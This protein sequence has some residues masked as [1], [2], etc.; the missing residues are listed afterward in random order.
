MRRI[1]IL[2]GWLVW[3]PIIAFAQEITEFPAEPTTQPSSEAT[4]TEVAD[5][6]I[7][8]A[9]NPTSP[10]TERQ[11]PK[12]KIRVDSNG[13]LVIEGR[14]KDIADLDYIYEKLLEDFLKTANDMPDIRFYKCKNIDVQ[15]LS[16]MLDEIFNGSSRAR[17]QA[18]MQMLQQQRAA[19]RAARSRRNQPG[20]EGGPQDGNERNAPEE[21][22]AE[23]TGIPGLDALFGGSDSSTAKNPLESMGIRVVPETQRGILWIVAATE[24][25]PSII[26]VIHT[27]DTEADVKRDYEVVNLSKLDA[28]EVKETIVE[29][30]GLEDATA[31]GGTRAVRSMN[32]GAQGED[33]QALAEQ[34]QQ[35]MIQLGEGASSFS[36]KDIRISSLPATNSII[37]F[38]PEE[39]RTSVVEIIK[40]VDEQGAETR[41]QSFALENANAETLAKT[42]EAVYSVSGGAGNR[43]KGSSIKI[44]ADAN[45]NTIYISAPPAL[46]TE[47]TLRIAEAE[48]QA[49]DVKPRMIQ[50][51]EGDAESIARVMD[52]AFAGK[53]SGKNKISIIA[54]AVTNQLIVTAPDEIYKDIT[55]LVELLDK[56]DADQLLPKFYPLQYAYAPEVKDKVMEMV[57][58]LAATD[59]GGAK[60][61][62]AFGVSADAAT[63]TLIVMGTPK[64]FLMMDLVLKQIDM[65][66]KDPTRR[67]TETIALV[68]ADAREV[69]GNINKLF[70][71]PGKSREGVDPPVAEANISTNAVVVAGTLKQI[72]DIKQFIKSLEDIATPAAG[73]EVQSYTIKLRYIDP[74]QA[75][76]QLNTIFQQQIKA[77]VDSGV[78]GI[79][80]SEKTVTIVADSIG[81]QLFV[82]ATEKNKLKIDEILAT[83]D[84]ED[85]TTA[86]SRLTE[87]FPIKYADPGSVVTAINNA[88]PSRGKLQEKE[89]VSAGVDWGTQ[90]VVV[91]ASEPNMQLI[92]GMIEKMD[93][94]T[95]VAGKPETIEL[96][97]AQ[98]SV[99]AGLV[100]QY[101]RETKDTNRKGRLPVSVIANEN[102]NTI[103]ISG[104]KE[105][106]L[107]T[108][109]ELVASMDVKPAVDAGRYMKVYRVRYVNLWSLLN[110]INQ[111]YN[112]G[113]TPE[114]DR[115]TANADWETGTL[116]VTANKTRHEEIEKLLADLD[117]ETQSTRSF[118]TIE[119]QSAD[120]LDV[121]NVLQQMINAQKT[122]QGQTRP[123]VTASSATNSL[124]VYMSENELAQFQP[125]IDSMD[126]EEVKGNAP[127]RIKLQHQNASQLADLLTRMFTEPARS[128]KRG[129]DQTQIPI[130]LADDAT[131]S[132]IVRAQEKDFNEISRMV[133]ELDTEA[134]LPTGSLQIIQVAPSI[135]VTE[136]GRMIQ[137]TMRD[138]EQQKKILNTNY[139]PA[140]VTIGVDAFTNSLIVSGTPAQVEE[141][142]RLVNELEKIKP[143][144]PTSIK[145]INLKNIRSQDLKQVLD[146]MIEERNQQQSGRRR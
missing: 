122:Q 23:S 65:E 133:S 55:A 120:A 64:V 24:L 9:T 82:N 27:L 57:K 58:Q 132:L 73:G 76:A 137:Q 20:A 2:S 139:K 30:L 142:Q 85:A 131:Q 16:S 110:T 129:S 105:D 93:I 12:L 116:M 44:S 75:A 70:G 74:D 90:S 34:L 60:S 80:D 112:S 7:D 17:Q 35:Q 130:I 43:A 8:E 140:L 45:T 114:T 145:V 59:P 33:P 103:I 46:M 66:P 125:L 26:E 92:R 29:L 102:S 68:K 19:E 48:S 143:A 123:T 81:K 104:G 39:A 69:A 31:R 136:F 11:K 56:P 138:R 62:G 124:I 106:E 77:L 118:K 84:T 128:Q 71:T 36:V 38:G 87:V 78:R 101:L 37:V 98:A 135:E 121:A 10:S 111:S 86:T 83:I 100:N 6:A 115:V 42:L 144:G 67:T 47:I 97:N 21:R 28:D 109:R 63:N 13:G 79:K 72:E 53:K 108:I 50:I 107:V 94:S 88:F 15:L 32:R 119:L 3:L 96:Q 14:P 134:E 22:G 146:Q 51:K 52:T 89:Q 49:S 126:S 18:Q 91:T 4:I 117:T 25:Y 95:G 1:I 141:V 41:V 99:V 127:Q 113:R 40:K 5:D 61:V 54:D